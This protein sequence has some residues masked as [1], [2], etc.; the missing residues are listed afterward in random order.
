MKELD[1][2]GLS[3]PMPLMHTK[4]ALEDGSR[5]LLVLA[6]SGTAKANVVALLSDAGFTVTVEATEAEYRITAVRD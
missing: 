5:E 6:D 4:K 3:C 1:V 2:R